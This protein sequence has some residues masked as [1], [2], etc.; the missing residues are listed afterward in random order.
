MTFCL[1]DKIVLNLKILHAIERNCSVESWVDWVVS[2]VAW[3]GMTHFAQIN[4]IPIKLESLAYIEELRVCDVS[5]TCFVS[6]RVNQ[7]VCSVL[8]LNGSRQI[9]LKLQIS[10]QKTNLSAHVDTFSISCVCTSIMC[11]LKWWIKGYDRVNRLIS[12]SSN[13]LFLWISSWKVSGSYSDLFSHYPINWIT[14][15]DCQLANR[16]RCLQGCP[17]SLPW[18]SMHFKL[19]NSHSKHLITI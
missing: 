11:E 15:G 9:S 14:E 16:S 19:S 2:N 13:C 4:W 12:N 6:G 8:T 5:N 1:I 18:L 3:R 7:D 10:T 17:Y